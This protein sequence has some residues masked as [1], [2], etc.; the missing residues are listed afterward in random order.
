VSENPIISFNETNKET[1]LVDNS[2][3]S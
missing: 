3:L 2:K 1:N